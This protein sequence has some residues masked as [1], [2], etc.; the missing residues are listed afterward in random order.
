MAAPFGTAKPAAFDSEN[1]APVVV[2]PTWTVND[3]GDAYVMPERT[4]GWE[5]AEFCAR[6]L[7]IDDEETGAF[8]PFTLTDEQLRF[9]CWFYA[10]NE[11]GKFIYRRSLFQRLKGHGKDPLAAAFALFEAVGNCRLDYFTDDGEVVG[12]PCRNAYVQIAA[13]TMEQPLALDTRVN[14]PN[15]WTTVGELTV[16]DFV[17]DE[18][19]N[20]QEVMRETPV[21]DGHKVYELT[22]DDGQRLRASANHGWTVNINNLRTGRIEER[23]T[24]TQEIADFMESGARRSVSINTAPVHHPEADLLLDP[25]MLGYWLGDGNSRNSGICVGRE[26]FDHLREQLES[27]ADETEHVTETGDFDRSGAKCLSIVKMKKPGNGRVESVYQKLRHEGLIKNKHVPDQYLRSSESQRRAL[28][29][30]M[31]DSDGHC[32]DGYVQFTN[33]NPLLI[34]GFVAL[35]RSLGY[36]PKV[37][38]ADGGAQYVRFVNHDKSVVARIERKQAGA[39]NFKR[40]RTGGRRYV[41]NIVEVASEPV[42]CIGIDTDSHLFQVEGGIL[43]HNTRNTSDMFKALLTDEA[44]EHFNFNLGMEVQYAKGGLVEIHCVTSNPRALEGKRPSFLIA[45]ETQN[46]VENNRGHKMYGVMKG[47]LIKHKDQCHLLVIANAPI[48]GED[49]VSER[50]I[51]AYEDTL[52]GKARDF[53]FLYDSLEA[54]A[55]APVDDEETIAD[56]I[57]VVRGDSVW[58][59]IEDVVSDF[60]DSLIPKSES[61]RKWFNQVIA[62]SDTLLSRDL[63]MSTRREGNLL[64]GDEIVLGMDGGRTGDATALVAIRIRDR[65]AVPIRIWE[66]SREDKEYV[67]P[68]E[69]V[70]SAV[71]DCFK[72]YKVKAFFS[73]VNLWESFIMGWV[74]DYGDQLVVRASG[75]SAIGWDMR[76]VKMSTLAHERFLNSLH[77]AG[78]F[79]NG[80][81]H[82]MQHMG[83]ATVRDNAFGRSFGKPGGRGSSR[84]VDAY[85]A[86][87]IAHEALNQYL[88]RG[89][90]KDNQKERTGRVHFY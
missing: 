59:P 9:A 46:W 28:L 52:I 64:P 75:H 5:L 26:D 35:A 67:V 43:T 66:G 86:L 45:N 1:W 10:I 33:K 13:T 39:V 20:S 56:I 76:G 11:R 23:T 18:D 77:N 31:V 44:I 38:K 69:Q 42:K 62:D 48:P 50:L 2:G 54:P 90:H 73:D 87:M 81:P 47:N 27:I 19:G 7:K 14:T 17:F 53:D 80:D 78:L 36:K 12:R 22:F 79:H 55:N 34:E 15:G 37:H 85:A 49:S 41:R 71:H 30:G 57:Q 16:G 61:R 84:K 51:T 32:W 63:I 65:L 72:R 82:L 58:L 88:E 68:H 74:E 8:R 24:T 25:Y 4:L 40:T 83:N 6:W 29:Q 3:D 60:F 70:E 21:M 89:S